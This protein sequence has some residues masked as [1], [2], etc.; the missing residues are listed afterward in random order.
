[1]GNR[2]LR[3]ILRDIFKTKTSREWL[4]FGN[5]FNT[6]L[7][8]VN[9]PR[10]LVEDP[11][12]KARFRLLPHDRH[13]IDMLSF[14]VNFVGETLPDPSRAPMVGEQSED[15]LRDILGYDAETRATL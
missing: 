2:E 6:P 8:P 13:G 9:T 15:V 1:R 3:S 12:F 10:N 7:A 14:P 4:D 5:R 11:Q